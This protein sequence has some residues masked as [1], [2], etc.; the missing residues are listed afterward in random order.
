MRPGDSTAV[1]IL[2]SSQATILAAIERDLAADAPEADVGTL[3]A[4]A[5]VAIDADV[6]A[7][8]KRGPEWA[9]YGNATDQSS[10][11]PEVLAATALPHP[12]AATTAIFNQETWTIALAADGA[13]SAAIL[14][15]TDW[16]LSALPFVRLAS[17]IVQRVSRTEATPA[18]VE[19]RPASPSAI[20]G[21]RIGRVHYRLL[22]RLDRAEGLNHV[23]EIALSHAVQAVHA[24]VG[25][26]ALVTPPATGALIVA[27]HGYSLALVDHVRIEPG[28][29]IIGAVLE[30]RRPLLEDGTTLS[31]KPRLRY[32]TTSF[33]VVPLLS[34]QEAIGALCVTDRAD[35]AAFAPRD[36]SILRVFAMSAVMAIRRERARELAETSAHQAAMDPVT[37]VFNRQYLQVRLEEELQRSKRHD[38]PIALLVIDIDEFKAV[39]DSYGH[40]IGDITLK[41]IAEILRRSVR[42]FDVCARF[43][44]DEFVIIMPGST[45]GS[46]GR[47]A[48]RI[49]T[50][51]E[52]YRA[53]DRVFARLRVTVSIGLAVS[54]R[55][56]NVGQLLERA[57]RALYTAKNSGK[58]QVRG[59]ELP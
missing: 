56:M 22:R 23:A 29:G 5:A 58:N 36:V 45:A 24:R 47:I 25:A 13:V 42:V 28:A 53:A 16:M 30:S 35:G 9:R 6:I 48:Q 33:V 18:A 15:E 7:F 38:I 3:L 21:R 8:V 37:G 46:A 52:Q 39:N 1:G 44:G 41:D 2:T 10:I 17:A 4:R 49:R 59:D 32:R 31:R 57:D 55:D 14:A 43:G 12:D 19:D 20:E 34:G 11:T 40:L 51:I 27:T 26:V 54:S 50:R